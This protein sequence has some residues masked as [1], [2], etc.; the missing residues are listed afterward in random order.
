MIGTACMAAGAQGGAQET[1]P[2][3]AAAG[4][5]APMKEVRV[6]ADAFTRGGPVPAWVEPVALP[7]T[8]SKRPIVTRLADSQFLIGPTPAFFVHRAVQSND[9]STLK[10]IGELQLNFVPDYQR[11]TLHFIRVLRGNETLDRTSSANIR[12]LQPAT[13]FENSVYTSAV[14][15]AIVLDDVRVGDTVEF[16]FSLEGQNPV[17]GSRYFESASWDSDDPVDLRRVVFTAPESRRIAW[18]SIGDSGTP[19]PDPKV[20]V[21][22]GM[23]T[24][25]FEGRSLEPV[26]VEPF[27]PNSYAPFRWLEFSEFESWSDVDAWARTLFPE[28]PASSPEF[29][30]L[31][32]TLRAEPTPAARASAALAWLQREIR[33]FSLSL[34]E[35]SHRPASPDLV[36]QRRFG[37]CKDK[38]YF[39]I[40]LL[41]AMG[42]EAHPVLMSTRRKS[43]QEQLLP[44]PGMFDHAIVEI[45]LDG[46]DYF[47]DPTLFEQKGRI[48]RIGQAYEG[49]QVLVVAAGTAALTTIPAAPEELATS[50]RHDAAVLKKFDGEGELVSTQTFV[51]P[52]AGLMRAVLARA[53]RKMIEKGIESSFIKTYPGATLAGPVEIQDDTEANRLTV[54]TRVRIPGFAHKSGKNWMLQFRPENLLGVVNPQMSSTR[55]FPMKVQAYPY[56]GRYSFAL[57]LPEEVS[58]IKD[59]STERV[60]SAFFEYSV[61]RSFR[62]RRATV[63]ME[64]HALADEVPAGKVAE[65]A[66]DVRKLGDLAGWFVLVTPDD[67]KKPG[68]LG[69]GTRTLHDTLVDRTQESIDKY[70]ATIESGKLGGLDL[71]QAYCERGVGYYTLAEFDKALAD[72]NEAV[73]LAPNDAGM[74]ACR[75]DAYFATGD[76]TRAQTDSSRAL[77][78]GSG[79]A[80]Y[81]MERGQARFY[82]KKYAE[83]ADDFAK[84]SSLNEDASSRAYADLWAVWT[85]SRAGKPLPGD[86]ARRAAESARGDWPRPALAMLTGDITPEQ[87][88]AI[89]GRKTGDELAMT[90]TEAYFALGQRYLMLGERAKAREAFEKVRA[91]GV[92]PYVEYIAAAFELKDLEREDR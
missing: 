75:S 45:R 1:A 56:V 54:T 48:D 39:L 50:E 67:L 86:I 53:E 51:G 23:R 72:V 78:L 14:T 59:P 17:F 79:A 57:E 21:A 4:A 11:I 28:N 82:L 92:V 30:K 70:S 71:A 46:R 3:P 68:F 13:E 47:V 36:L 25:R 64:F 40:S 20:T 16:A 31:V 63:D 61:A 27:T 74:L 29:H 2:A 81:F 83:A 76:F 8:A 60:S 19:I 24:L 26:T 44:S 12:F 87:M 22:G 69:I 77:L 18:K 42:I 15:A 37:D 43:R 62:G 58:A 55:L 91:L 41:D 80:R 85:H 34:G 84:A 89:V 90:Q 9:A 66:A 73:R 65:Y 10:K 6:A 7:E 33:Y 32:E 5:S 49:A 52:G 35:S 88:L 38:A